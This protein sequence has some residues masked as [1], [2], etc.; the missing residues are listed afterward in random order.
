MDYLI[1]PI[2]PLDANGDCSFTCNC[3]VG[4]CNEKSG[5]DTCIIRDSCSGQCTNN[6]C[7]DLACGRGVA[8]RI[9]M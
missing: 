8:R 5:P 9:T 2:S 1:D 6:G 4:S 3:Y 7:W